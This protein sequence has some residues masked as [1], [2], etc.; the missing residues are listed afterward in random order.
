MPEHPRPA[1]VVI[2]NHTHGLGIVRS[3]GIAGWPAWMLNDTALGLARF[4]RYLRGYRTLQRGTL[5][6]LHVESVADYLIR[7]LL[8]LSVERFSLLFAVNEDVTSFIFRHRDRLAAKYFI[9]AVRLERIYD[10]YAFNDLLPEAMRIETFLFDDAIGRIEDPGQYLVK[11]RKGN[12]FRR[13]IGAKAVPLSLFLKMHASRIVHQLQPHDLIVQRIVTSDEPVLSLCSFCI[14][15]QIQ[16]SFQYEKLRQHPD[17]FGTGTYLRSVSV[18]GIH[19]LGSDVLRQLA[20][21]GI[22]EIEFIRDSTSGGYRVIEMN[23]RTWKSTHF[24]TQCGVNLVDSYLT[25]IAS[26]ERKTI[27][28]YAVNRYWVDL[29]TDIPQLIRDRTFARYHWGLHESSW[30]RADPLP[31][32]AL[33]GLSPLIALDHWWRARLSGTPASA[34]GAER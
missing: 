7:E 31:G 27:D 30:N 5:A 18:P 4:S 8:S 12:A 33:W 24:A 20:F 2:G 6:A 23:P 29:A 25:Y 32:L 28:E 34:A 3:A 13:L 1:A 17:R 9:P 14:E 10:K 21:T 16:S 19:A 11:G 22:S 26:G 15:G